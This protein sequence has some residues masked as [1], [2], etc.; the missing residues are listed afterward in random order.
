MIDVAANLKYSELLTTLASELNDANFS[1]RG[2][3]FKVMMRESNDLIAEATCIRQGEYSAE[4]SYG[5]IQ[6][7]TS[8]SKSFFDNYRR[9]IE[10]SSEKAP[11][12]A[13]HSATTPAS[14]SENREDFVNNC[15]CGGITWLLFHELAHITQGHLSIGVDNPNAYP[16]GI[17][18]SSD[19]SGCANYAEIELKQ[20]KELAADYQA[21]RMCAI[22]IL[23][24]HQ[25][26]PLSCVNNL[27]EMLVGVTILFYRLYGCRGEI[28]VEPP[29][30][31]HPHP[32][33]RLELVIAH[34]M[35][36]M[37]ILHLASDST[38]TREEGR[39]SMV[40]AC[41]IASY[42]CFEVMNPAEKVSLE[43]LPLPVLQRDGSPAY[44]TRIVAV[45][46]K[47]L[48]QIIQNDTFI[49]PKLLMSF[50]ESF[51]QRLTTTSAAIEP[52]A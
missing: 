25:E 49:D 47:I 11:I 19:Q 33:V 3:E 40:L 6:Q 1:P 10:E 13:L 21:S 28:H 34:V 38:L 14:F 31:S 44:F 50:N 27:H 51:R 9:I 41:W 17:S 8:D 12:R 36:V 30:G 52:L 32:V 22:E 35:E 39:L 7:L 5:L 23:R 4:I 37:D 26:N 29:K 2:H 15:I 18:E 45:W 42:Y 20:T 46:D 48:P 16:H 43:H 24:H